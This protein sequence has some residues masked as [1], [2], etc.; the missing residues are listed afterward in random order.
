VK[1]G[2][3]HIISR[4]AFN[5]AAKHYPNEASSLDTIYKTLRRGTFNTPEEL[6]NLFPSLD[7]MKYK[8]KWWVIDVGGS[9]LRIL[10]FASFDTQKIFVKQIVTHAEYDR[11]MQ[12]YR[13]NQ[14]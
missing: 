4:E 1:E 8:A 2:A 13:R 6:K 11:L 10:F 3:M 12:Q 5:E 14:E 9:H 7:R